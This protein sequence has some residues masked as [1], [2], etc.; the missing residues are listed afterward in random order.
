MHREL[1]V[2]PEH[3]DDFLI[4]KENDHHVL[5]STLNKLGRLPVSFR[6]GTHVRECSPRGPISPNNFTRTTT[7]MTTVDGHNID[8]DRVY[9]T[10]NPSN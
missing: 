1:P 4:T 5:T 8:K 3:I 2:K 10:L 6:L 7:L 9:L